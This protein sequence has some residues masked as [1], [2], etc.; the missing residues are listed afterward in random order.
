MPRKVS[1]NQPANNNANFDISGSAN[2]ESGSV[3]T[4]FRAKK[5]TNLPET[6]DKVP[7]KIP[8]LP[9]L[10]IFLKFDFNDILNKTNRA[11]K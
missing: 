2:V 11:K 8:K 4:S 9:N 1:I 10:V 3:I 5:S 6:E 7:E